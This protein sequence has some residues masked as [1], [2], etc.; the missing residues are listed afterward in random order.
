[1]AL[2]LDLDDTLR[3]EGMARELVRALNDLRKSEGLEIADRVVVSLAA[4]AD[5]VAAVEAH[6]DWIAGEVL[7]T[8]LAVVDELDEVTA[9]IT[10]DEH[11]VRVQLAL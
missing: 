3:R 6:R 9:T 5:V 11:Q 4:P 7:A 1:V 10:V 8:S 2:D